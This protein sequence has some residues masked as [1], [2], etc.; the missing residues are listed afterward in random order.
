MSKFTH[1]A[2]STWKGCTVHKDSIPCHPYFHFDFPPSKISKLQ[3]KKVCLV[4]T[5]NVR[6]SLLKRLFLRLCVYKYKVDARKFFLSLSFLKM[7]RV[8]TFSRIYLMISIYT[9]C[10]F[11]SINQITPY[12]R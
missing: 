7:T 4:Y 3:N 1:I 11:Y 2:T 6:S 9:L 5:K 10:L 12:H 8:W